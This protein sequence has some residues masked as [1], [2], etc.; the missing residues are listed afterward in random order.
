MKDN[1][2][3]IRPEVETGLVPVPEPRGANHPPARASLG[4]LGRAYQLP[5]VRDEARARRLL[6]Q[7]AVVFLRE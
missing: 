2:A 4:R 5:P 3:V 6:L 7:G 1:V